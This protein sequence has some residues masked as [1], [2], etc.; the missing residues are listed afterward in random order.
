MNNVTLAQL[1]IAA[2][3]AA[4]KV[5][6]LPTQDALTVQTVKLEEFATAGFDRADFANFE[7]AFNTQLDLVKTL[8]TQD[9]PATKAAKAAVKGGS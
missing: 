1:V 5:A 8:G 2:Q 3:A 4:N 7:N 9:S 6:A